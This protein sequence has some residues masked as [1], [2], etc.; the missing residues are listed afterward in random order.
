MVW[1][2]VLWQCYGIVWYRM[3]SFRTN[4]TVFRGVIYYGT[5]RIVLW[6]MV[7]EWCGMCMVRC[8]IVWYD[9]VS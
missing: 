9:M 3:V 4:G 6:G 5:V 2:S 7:C 8:D 1:Y